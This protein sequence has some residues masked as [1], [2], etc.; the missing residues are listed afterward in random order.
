MGRPF[1]K[2]TATRR[3]ADAVPVTPGHERSSRQ[4]TTA[5]IAELYLALIACTIFLAIRRCVAVLMWKPSHEKAR[6]NGDPLQAA[7]AF[8]K[9]GIC[10][11]AGG[12]VCS[13]SNRALKL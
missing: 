8:G 3:E 11:P 7:V 10:D 4:G 5:G 1:H 2:Q 13:E 6:P 12:P 9:R